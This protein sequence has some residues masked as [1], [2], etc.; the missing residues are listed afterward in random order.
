MD[1]N[2]AIDLTLPLRRGMPLYPGD[3]A[4]RLRRILSRENGDPLTSSEISI[5]C[6]VGTHADAPAHFHFRRNHDRS[7]GAEALLRRCHRPRPQSSPACHRDRSA[8]PIHS[9]APAHHPQDQECRS[10]EQAGVFGGLLSCDHRCGGAAAGSRAPVDRHRL[11]QP[12]SGI[13]ILRSRP[14][15]LWQRPGCRCSSVSIYARSSRASMHSA[16]SARRSPGPRRCRSE[17]SCHADCQTGECQTGECQTGAE[18]PSEHPAIRRT[19]P[20]APSAP[21]SPAAC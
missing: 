20:A 21:A 11:L 3:H 17:R 14:T 1:F 7:N 8:G 6:H 16:P 19:A 18:A 10:V 2:R 15:P 13:E 12:R 4:P 9:Q 5:N